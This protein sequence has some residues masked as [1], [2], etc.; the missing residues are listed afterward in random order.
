MSDKEMAPQEPHRRPWA[1]RRARRD[2]LVVGALLTVTAAGLVVIWPTSSSGGH[3][4]GESK[5][6]VSWARP[7]VSDTG[8][9]ARS[10]VR[11]THVATT[12]GGGLVDL[13]Y[14]VVDPDAAA[15][16][17]GASTPPAIVDEESGLIVQDLLM[18]HS[19][20]GSFKAGVSYYYVF[21]DPVNWVHRGD[22]VTVLLGDAQVE[23]VVVK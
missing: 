10:G 14:E 4:H 23:H 3:D 2:G 5:V 9:A 1:V 6:P 13:R 15:A 20:S 7:V 19:H 16:L 11:I 8:L 21:I 17:H 12:G 22:K 18:G